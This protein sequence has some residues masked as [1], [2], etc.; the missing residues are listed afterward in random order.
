MRKNVTAGSRNRNENVQE[1]Y[2]A[3]ESSVQMGQDSIEVHSGLRDQYEIVNH[4]HDESTARGT[5]LSVRQSC[6]N[7]SIKAPKAGCLSLSDGAYRHD[8]SVL[9]NAALW[10]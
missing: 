1:Q 5:A 2:T 4:E 6:T 8:A 3:P 9:L 7:I 10:I